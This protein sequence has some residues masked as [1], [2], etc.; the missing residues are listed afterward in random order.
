MKGGSGGS[1]VCPSCPNSSGG[2]GPASPSFSQ[3]IPQAMINAYRG[4]AD[5]VEN[6]NNAFAGKAPIADNSD[7]SDQPI[8]RGISSTPPNVDLPP[9]VGKMMSESQMSVAKV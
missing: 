9:N 6:T 7:I 8:A 5:T 1:T 3:F 4:A 2:V